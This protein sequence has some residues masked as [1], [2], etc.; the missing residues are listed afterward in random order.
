MP[1][2]PLAQDTELPPASTTESFSVPPPPTLQDF[3]T[4]QKTPAL[5]PMAGEPSILPL[6]ERAAAVQQ[7]QAITLPKISFSERNVET[8]IPL[9]VETGVPS[10]TYFQTK[11]NRLKEDQLNYLKGVYGDENV[12]L[13][14]TG[15]P[16]VRVLDSKTGKPKD[17]TL[18]PEKMSLRDVADVGAH[19]MEIL[20]GILAAKRGDVRGAINQA[21]N[22]GRMSIGTE[23]GG[24]LQDVATR[25]LQGED[26]RPME[27]TTSRAT[28]IPLDFGAG[29]FMTGAGKVIGKAIS[30]FSDPMPA[31]FN[32]QEAK[33]RLRAKYGIDLPNTPGELTGSTL[34]LRA[35]QFARQKPGSTG[36]F[37]KITEAQDAAIQ[38]VQDILTGRAPATTSEETG[39]TA[40]Q[41]IGA[42]L[43]PLRSEVEGLKKGVQASATEELRGAVQTATGTELRQVLDKQTIGQGLREAA[44]SARD[45]WKQESGYE[46]FFSNPITKAETVSTKN[47]SDRAAEILRS[48]PGED[49]MVS[50]PSGVLDASGKP[51]LVDEMGR[52]VWKEF[53]P[54]GVL[55]RLQRLASRPNAKV[56]LDQLK[57]MRTEIDDNILMGEA[58]PGV[59]NLQLKRVRSMLTDAMNE[60]V[61]SFGD[62]ALSTEWKRINKSY[63]ENVPRFEQKGIAEIF[64]DA[65]NPNFIG[66]TQLVQRAA[67]NPDIYKE[68][69]KFFGKESPV[70]QGLQRRIAEDVLGVSSNPINGLVDG[71]TFVNNLKNLWKNHPD[72]ARDAF[73]PDSSKLYG[74]ATA[75][76]AA[77]VGERD[78]AGMLIRSVNGKVDLGDLEDLLRSGNPTAQKL[79]DLINA[80]NKL[81]IQ[82]RNGIKKV[83][84]EGGPLG[85]KIEPTEFVNYFSRQGEPRDIKEIMA[86]LA[87]RSDVTESIRR[88]TMLDILNRARSSGEALKHEFGKPG[89]LNA[90][91]LEEAMGLTG[92]GGATQSERYRA[93]LGDDTWRDLTDIGHYLQPR[94]AGAS[95]F[96]TAG[97]LSAG[98]QIAQ[99]ERGSI[100]K[101]LDTAVKNFIVAEV[102]SMPLI[103]K[104]VANTAM[105]PSNQASLVSY[106][107]SSTPFVESL[108]HH[109]GDERSKEVAAQIK[110][111]IDKSIPR[112]GASTAGESINGVPKPMPLEYFK[113]NAPAK[114]APTR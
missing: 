19:G 79:V 41:A 54:E 4:F 101:F 47:I 17:I 73:G 88:Q 16:I 6:S 70:M 35:E 11:L 42:K 25:G 107:V 90:G 50:V 9:D 38:F 7:G 5:Q 21:K 87:D 65:Q 96:G 31:Q 24:A 14:D 82:Y 68:Y 111:A 103:R 60:A 32:L 55:N 92:K 37:Q 74:I 53:V 105:T 76:T 43:N 72:L 8:G 84:S 15:D 1:D 3:T 20:G 109:F 39:Q 34:L 49:K 18:A 69:V 46:E 10:W 51:I 104:W 13:A 58:V 40:L 23:L 114:R 36:A 44:H 89:P 86:L 83:V 22:I 67:E 78:R 2:D 63:A 45:A 59:R 98:S 102:Y 62:P 108:V 80:Q 57:Q 28:S 93:I 29:L 110:F 97:R 52:E 91:N 77:T 99:L 66:N 95:T 12:R 33:A 81:A 112:P 85:E 100:F 27:I 71:K 106:M 94:E 56:S 75:E 26:I 113:T 30:P 48:M 64:H 61:D